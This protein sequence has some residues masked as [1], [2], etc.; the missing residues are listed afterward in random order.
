MKF[1]RGFGIKRTPTRMSY[2]LQV[3]N[4]ADWITESV[5]KIERLCDTTITSKYLDLKMSLDARLH[6][7]KGYKATDVLCE[8]LNIV[9]GGLEQCF[10]VAKWEGDDNRDMMQAH[11]LGLAPKE[12]AGAV[13]SISVQWHKLQGKKIKFLDGREFTVRFFEC[14][15]YPNA[16]GV[17]AKDLKVISKKDF[18]FFSD[19]VTNG[20]TIP[21]GKRA[22]GDLFTTVTLT[23]E[24]KI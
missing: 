9:G 6:Q 23:S 12:N 16:C 4:L 3:I 5:S 1:H 8:V 14:Y 17:I 15:D 7:T 2:G 19:E 22:I 20:T 10:S 13:D 24:T 11:L 21:S 18:C